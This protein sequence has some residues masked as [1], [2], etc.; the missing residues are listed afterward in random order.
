MFHYGL[1]RLSQN[2]DEDNPYWWLIACLSTVLFCTSLSPIV[3][4]YCLSNKL[5]TSVKTTTKEKQLK[6]IFEQKNSK[7]VYIKP[8]ANID[9]Q[10][11]QKGVTRKEYL[12]R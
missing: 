4:Q 8:A 3:I 2:I 1:R 9:L 11:L 7:L 12:S 5:V 10:F 6:P